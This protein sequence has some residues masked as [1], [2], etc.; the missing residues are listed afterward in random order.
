MKPL[1]AVASLVA[2]TAT[3]SGCVVGPRPVA[4]PYGYDEAVIVAPPPP[5]VEYY[6]APP[7]AGQIWI[8][9]Y[10]NWSGSRHEWVPGRWEAPRPGY[11]WVPH[12]W[13]RDGDRW[14]QRGGHWE[15]RR[16]RER[17]RDHDHD[18]RERRGW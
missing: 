6:G 17:N 14:R 11:S 3:L 1:F 5:R 10:W 15:E 12:R 7:V 13:E 4:Q 8:E 9:G 18:R 2:L 16:D